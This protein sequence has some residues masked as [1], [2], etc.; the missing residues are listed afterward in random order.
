MSGQLPELGFRFQDGRLHIFT[1]EAS[2]LIRGWPNPHAVRKTQGEQTWWAFRPEFRLVYPYRRKPR[3]EERGPVQLALLGPNALRPSFIS[4]KKP[5][6]DAFRFSL[7]KMVARALLGFQRNQWRPLAMLH[8]WGGPAEDLF[9][10]NPALAFYLAHF[11]S[12][13]PDLPV[14]E[15]PRDIVKAKQRDITRWLGLPG[16]NTAV[17]ILRK[18]P[19]ESI[20]TL[21][22]DDMRSMLQDSAAVRL[23]VHVPNIN[24]GVLAL[25]EWQRL[26]PAIT[27]TLLRE[28]AAD[29]RQKYTPHTATLLAHTLHLHRELHPVASF[30]QFH[31]L[32][33]LQIRHD[34]LVLEHLRR[35]RRVS[36]KLKGLRFWRPPVPGTPDIEPIVTGEDLVAEGLTQHNCV[37]SYASRI[38]SRKIYIYRVLRPERATLCITRQPDGNWIEQELKKAHNQ[39]AS[40]KTAEAVHDWLLMHGVR[41]QGAEAVS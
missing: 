28:V 11:R 32:T 24:A 37:A 26:R 36:G 2:M 8:A 7:P 4:G 29:K 41:G 34:A 20:T 9:A 14:Q 33:S 21:R 39:P 15:V 27:A 35:V 13:L 31:S 23:L 17:K 30:P 16:S 19:P 12:F 40:S 10:S 5:A 22:A 18:I 3:P 6:F 25:V 38:M 1:P